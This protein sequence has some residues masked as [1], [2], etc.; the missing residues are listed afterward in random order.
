MMAKR[1]PKAIKEFTS[2]AYNQFGIRVVVLAAYIDD[3]GDPS[4]SL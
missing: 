4:I 2:S 3:E 1:G